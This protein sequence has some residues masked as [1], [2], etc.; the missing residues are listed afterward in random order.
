MKI[1]DI[2][3]ALGEVAKDELYEMLGNVGFT[4]LTLDTDI[5]QKIVK[6]LEKKYD[7]DIKVS[8]K[9]KYCNLQNG[10]KHKSK[11]K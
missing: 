1:K 11:Y 2:L 10:K 9:V 8:T 3:E 4:N 6:K 5:P 7:K